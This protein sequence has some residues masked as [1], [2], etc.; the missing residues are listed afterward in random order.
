[1]AVL[2]SLWLATAIE[3]PHQVSTAFIVAASSQAPNR[4]QTSL[5][6]SEPLS[7]VNRRAIPAKSMPQKASARMVAQGIPANFRLPSTS[8]SANCVVL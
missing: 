4:Y 8:A 2:T 6:S 5:G 7:G 1:M 3:T